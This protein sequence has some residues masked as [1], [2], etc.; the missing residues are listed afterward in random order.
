M[1][2]APLPMEQAKLDDARGSCALFTMLDMG[3]VYSYLHL[4]G[5]ASWVA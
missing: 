2:A 4:L 5:M 3:V 1:A